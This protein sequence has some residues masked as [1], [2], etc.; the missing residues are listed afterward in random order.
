MAAQNSAAVSV[1][2]PT[3]GGGI[4]AGPTDA[5][6]P[7]DAVEALPAALKNLGYANAD[8]VVNAIEKEFESVIAW[9]GDEVLKPMTSRTETFAFGF[10]QNDADVMS[11]VYGAENVT[12]TE[13]GALTV[14]HNAL[15]L[16]R[17]AYVFQLALTGG[18]K[19]RIVVPNGQI[20]EVGE[21]SYV[22][23]DPISYN[24]TLSAF[25]DEAGNTAYVYMAAIAGE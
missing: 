14:L 19:M 12:E 16:P 25:P 8:G 4:F 10:L 22:D 2:K 11:E 23:G 21:V 13:D 24:V 1:G 17:R 6:L 7:T 15:E 5:T 18:R 9:G 20:T 3:T